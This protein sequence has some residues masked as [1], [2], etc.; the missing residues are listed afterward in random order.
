MA[1]QSAPAR[2]R[3]KAKETEV[4]ESALEWYKRYLVNTDREA[5]SVHVRTRLAAACE[6]L[7]RL[8][9]EE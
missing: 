5:E 4:I 8:R 2:K 9:R 6:R 1:T 3:H 7:K